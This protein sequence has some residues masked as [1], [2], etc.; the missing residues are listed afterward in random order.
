MNEES[1]QQDI[2]NPAVSNEPELEPRKEKTLSKAA[3]VG[4]L[5]LLVVIASFLAYSSLTDQPL[6]QPSQEE[7][8]Q[9]VRNTEI[10][11][12]V[13]HATYLV[14][15]NTMLET[16][17]SQP[18][19]R[20]DSL[21]AYDIDDDGDEDILGFFTLTFDSG[22]S[23]MI[24]STWFRNGDKYE[25]YED[26]FDT[27]RIYPD[28]LEVETPCSIFDLAFE[29]V[30][31]KCEDSGEEYQ[32]TLKYQENEVGY[33]RD[34]DAHALTFSDEEDWSEYTSALGGVSFK[35][36]S[37]VDVA[38]KTYSVFGDPITVITGVQDDDTLFEIHSV[39]SDGNKGGG[40]I[41]LSWKGK[42]LKL[43][44]GSYLSRSL[45]IPG[46][47]EIWDPGIFYR[48]TG[49]YK[50]NNVGS[51]FTAHD[52]PNVAKGRKYKFFSPLQNEDELVVVDKI[53]ASLEYNGTSFIR[54]TA[55]IPLQQNIVTITDAITLTVPGSISEK[56]TSFNPEDSIAVKDMELTFV[57]SPVYAPY[58][59]TLVVYPFQSIGGTNSIGGGG[60]N[61]EEDKCFL[62]DKNEL[63]APQKIGK[64]RVCRFGWG[65]GGLSTQGYY[66]LDPNQNFILSIRSDINPSTSYA[67]ILHPDLEAIVESVHF[68][69]QGNN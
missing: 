29:R 33:Y 56:Q 43:S 2:E 58:P 46:S 19:V 18:E 25:Y 3:I 42:F 40:T 57:D 35:I 49:A 7:A 53:F 55:L 26:G 22:V 66:V 48:K 14:L 5:I 8:E 31:L 34:V 16:L 61:L 51:I 6:D 13:S 27:F 54:D 9:V 60:Y 15:Q 23:A 62:F 63:S 21:R 69:T 41:D 50:E 24:F 12:P 28:N 20:K 59:L 36:P 65:D 64:N 39:L 10:G 4:V 68:S 38:E 30:T 67:L 1:N 11:S 37:N 47:D 32:I 45:M 17:P 52:F 44:D